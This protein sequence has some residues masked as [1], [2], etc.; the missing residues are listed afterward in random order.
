M[1]SEIQEG[2]K[3]QLGFQS[4]QNCANEANLVDK[5]DVVVENSGVETV[6]MRQVTL[7]QRRD[8]PRARR[9]Y[10]VL[11]KSIEIDAVSMNVT[12]KL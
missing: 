11:A 6:D 4:N 10:D 8:T 5:Q 3:R 2:V 9:K 12:F 1:E 7:Q